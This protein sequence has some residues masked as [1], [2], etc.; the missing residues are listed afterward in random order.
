M[1]RI[2]AALLLFGILA[3]GLVASL[4]TV[5]AQTPVQRLSG[6]DQAP[7]P[8]GAA[9]ATATAVPGI[10]E[11]VW[12]GTGV[13]SDLQCT[14]VDFCVGVGTGGM[15]ART[16]TSGAT[17]HF[18]ILAPDKDLN[19]LSFGDAQHALIVGSGGTIYR[20]TDGAATWQPVTPLN[21]ADLNAVSMLADGSAWAAGSGGAIWHSADGG[22]TWTAQ[23]S[24]AGVDLNAI[25]F[26]D[27]ATGF[28]AG[29]SGVVLRTS[30]GGATWA[31]VTS[32]FPVSANINTLFFTSPQAGW[33]AGQT[34]L[35]RRTT[36]GG[37]TWQPVASGVSADILDIHFAGSFGVFGA[38]NGLVATSTGGSVWNVQTGETAK[39]AAMAV[40][41]VNPNQVWAAGFAQRP[42]A[43]NPNGAA[44]E[45]WWVY[46]SED[47]GPF[48]L[49][50]GDYFPQWQE[51][52]YP[53][54]NVAYVAGQQ[55]AVLKT[56]D[57]GDTWTW[58]RADPSSGYF[59][60]LSCPDADHCWGGG[61]YASVYATSDGGKTWQRQVLPGAGKPVYDMFMW[62]NQRGLA[63]TNGFTDS[64]HIMYRT[65]DGGQTWVE[66]KTVGRHP[67]SGISMP[68][69]TTGWVA[70]RNWS[71]WKTSDGG[72]NFTRILDERLA[73]NIYVDTAVFD[74]NG[75]NKVD[76]GWLIGCIGPFGAGESCHAPP[77]GVIRH[78]PD[79]GVNWDPV[80]VPEGTKP[81]ISLKMLDS[82]HGWAGGDDGELV[83]MGE[84]R[85]WIKVDS[86]LPPGNSAIQGISFADPQHGLAAGDSGY[87]IRF[88][89]AGRTLDSYPQPGPITV[90]GQAGDW[91]LGGDLTLDAGNANAVLGPEPAPTPGELSAVI[92]SRWTMSTL[93][94]LAEIKDEH[95]SDQSRLQ[96][97]FDGRNDK[98]WN[99][100][101][102][103]LITIG[104]DGSVVDDLHPGQPPNLTAQVGRSAAGWT[105]ELAIPAATLGRADF[106]GAD[107]V[108]F[109]FAVTGGDSPSHT[110]VFAGTRIDD[111]PALFGTIQLLGDTISYQRSDAYRGV[112]DTYLERW[113]D[114]SGTTPR[115]EE[116]ILQV[117]NSNDQVYS[118]AL[119]RFEL[120][121]L[122][123]GSQVTSATLDLTT[124]FASIY[125]EPLSITAYRL[126]KPWLE[127]SATW[128]QPAVGQSWGMAGAR[129]PG[130]DYDPTKLSTAN[131]RNPV[132]PGSHVQWDLTGAVQ[133]WLAAPA[134]NDGVL[135]LPEN[136]ARYLKSFSSEDEHVENRPKLTV[137]FA[138][139][140]RPATPTPTPSPTPND[141]PTPTATPS[142]T[143]TST[144]TPTATPTPTSVPAGVH[145]VVYEDAN[146]NGER[147]P[148]E[149]ALAGAQ[150]HLTGPGVDQS[151]TTVGD[152][153]YAF[154]NLGSGQYTLAE[155]PPPG[156]GPSTPASPVRLALGGGAD[157]ALDF[158]HT[159][160]ATATATP[161]L[162]PQGHLYLPLLRK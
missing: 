114:Q 130:V 118:D 40:F 53:T 141:T 101:D 79:G 156:F 24:G 13:L 10:W 48:E 7:D 66:S 88:K 93:Y 96:V 22:A 20:T 108:G 152:G 46:K 131:L 17:W 128:M 107:A 42:P 49:K 84:D 110:L 104:A 99:G 151:L 76:Q 89:P 61:R 31:P 120:E 162:E 5:T 97:A 63:G 55:W 140:P 74:D 44:L 81:L 133:T 145:G 65:D 92:H 105:V 85:H 112:A 98:L 159:R 35:M 90:D 9:A 19:A 2:L 57:G 16:A 109:N 36:D 147:D 50:A 29:D 149:Q 100:F 122:P 69:D 41:A 30:D 21:A 148:G 45:S 102:D 138:L 26:L 143:A 103:Q 86:G 34:G 160:L 94:L 67:A 150:L 1:K 28:A 144:P 25:Q 115:G 47:G 11:T 77:T 137:R 123:Q 129:Q 72:R 132:N 38:D 4:H 37:A 78:T 126:L 56:V 75:D 161:T 52:A 139:Q 51:V 15:A 157:L 82:H 116:T 83:Y 125:D 111:N 3:A 54:P 136:G 135:L 95:V 39:R 12:R 80:E 23:T 27:A 43:E 153:L 70:L 14:S 73:P 68:T 119:L 127:P 32:G 158:G 106:A 8:A 87:V 134:S 64:T 154:T 18:D 113:T 146:G 60:S 121:G 33:I 91:Y 124:Y 155:T 62:D 6:P 142:P 71:Y 117:L 59:A 58:L